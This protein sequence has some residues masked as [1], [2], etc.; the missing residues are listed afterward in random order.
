MVSHC[1]DDGLSLLGSEGVERG[2][3]A[4]GIGSG[5]GVIGFWG[6]DVMQKP[7][8]L[9]QQTPLSGPCRVPAPTFNEDQGSGVHGHFFCMLDAVIQILFEVG[10][11]IPFATAYKGIGKEKSFTDAVECIE[12]PV[13]IDPVARSHLPGFEHELFYDTI[14]H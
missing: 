10:E 6:M 5:S 13:E 4:C 8:K 7:G 12:I 14:C 3:L 9:G 1:K 11:H 2:D